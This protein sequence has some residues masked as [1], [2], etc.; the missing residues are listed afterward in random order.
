MRM[1]SEVGSWNS[2]R[3]VLAGG[4]SGNPCSPHYDDLIPLWLSGDGV[5]IAWG[6]DAVRRSTESALQLTPETR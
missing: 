1:V 5:V 6:E 4:Q 3:F 2:T